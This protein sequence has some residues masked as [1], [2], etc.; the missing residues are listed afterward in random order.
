MLLEYSPNHG[1]IGGFTCCSCNT[2]REE[3]ADTCDL[4]HFDLDMRSTGAIFRVNALAASDTWVPGF[5]LFPEQAPKHWH[6]TFLRVRLAFLILRTSFLKVLFF[7]KH[8]EMP[9]KTHARSRSRPSKPIIATEFYLQITYKAIVPA[10]PGLDRPRFLDAL[11]THF[12]HKTPLPYRSDPCTHARIRG[13]HIPHVLSNSMCTRKQ[14]VSSSPHDEGR[15]TR[16]I[17]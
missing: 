14:C 12:I 9:L 13:T 7:L 5:F 1:L 4:E 16:G 11:L 3:Q 17:W 10:Y 2:L 6:R 15:T 8:D